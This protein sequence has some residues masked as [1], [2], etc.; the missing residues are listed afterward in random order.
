MQSIPIAKKL[1]QL[2]AAPKSLQHNV[3]I[4]FFNQQ[5]LS[6]KSNPSKLVL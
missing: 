4:I 3:N 1:V 5:A 2:H 6:R